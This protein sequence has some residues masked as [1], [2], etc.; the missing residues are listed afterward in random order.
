MVGSMEMKMVVKM[1]D[2]SEFHWAVMT[3]VWKVVKTVV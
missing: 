1:V 2:G 3:E